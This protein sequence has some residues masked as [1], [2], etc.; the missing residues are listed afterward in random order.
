M[1]FVRVHIKSTVVDVFKYLS[2]PEGE[3]KTLTALGKCE[4]TA[5]E[6][7]KISGDGLY[8]VYAYI[9]RLMKRDLVER[10][11]IEYIV[12]GTKLKRVV[13]KATFDDL[14]IGTMVYET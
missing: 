10:V 7:S 9:K 12:R 8:C 11:D 14:K 1:A 2:V 6:I 13:W 4:L 3:L 5:T